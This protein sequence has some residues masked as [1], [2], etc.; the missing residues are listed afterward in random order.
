MSSTKIKCPV[1]LAEID[2]LEALAEGDL[3]AVLDMQDAFYPHSRLVRAYFELFGVSPG[4][5]NVHRLRVLTE[6]MRSLFEREEYSY[7]RKSTGFP[8]PASPRPFPGWSS[9]ASGAP[10]EPQLF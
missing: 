6:E 2:V 8:A 1:C 9:A 5:R 10:E 4:F 7:N 3:R